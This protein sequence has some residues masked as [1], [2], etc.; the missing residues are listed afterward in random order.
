[1]TLQSL[2]GATRSRG[3]RERTTDPDAA[4]EG[5]T[6]LPVDV[7]ESRKLGAS[8]RHV[9]STGAVESA[10]LH[11]GSPLHVSFRM[12]RI[13][14]STAEKVITISTSASS[15]RTVGI[16]T[17]AMTH[18]RLLL[19]PLRA[20]T[21]AST[22]GSR[23]TVRSRLL[24]PCAASDAR[25][26]SSDD[27]NVKSYALT[28]RG[29]GVT[30]TVLARHHEIRLDLPKTMGGADGAPQ[31]VELLVAALIGCEQATAAYCARHMSP[32]FPLKHVHF[33]YAAAR[34]D[35][36]ATSLPIIEPP[37]VSARMQRVT[38][39]AVVHLSRGAETP[40]RVD[41]LRRLVEARCPVANTLVA[42]GCELDVQWK[43]ADR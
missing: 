8:T 23:A 36:G 2:S 12:T 1:M 35:R 13:Q 33:T 10:P 22:P 5:S 18:A 29:S 28:G 25:A 30:A 20:L 31:P 27:A 37:P 7:D 41:Q 38:G 6:H 34:D 42:A 16:P 19:A 14:C 9:Q 17:R 3:A 40:E 21:R 32:R 39:T 24:A 43:L 4:L 26:Y 11:A 15:P